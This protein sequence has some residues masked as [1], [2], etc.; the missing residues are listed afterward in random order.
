MAFQ[1]RGIWVDAVVTL[2]SFVVYSALVLVRAQGIPLHRV[3]YV[4]PMLWAIGIGILVVIVGR[5]AAGIGWPEDCGKTDARDLEI[6][7]FGDRVG[8]SFLGLSGLAAL[9]L[10]MAEASHFWIANAIY[11]GFVVSVL[12]GSA[13]KLAAYRQG[14]PDL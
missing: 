7:R 9:G 13:M 11:L 4:A 10:C 1:E 5:I 8:Q 12:V 14:I 6:G 3:A 2:C